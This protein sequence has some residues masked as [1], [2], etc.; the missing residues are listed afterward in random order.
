MTLRAIQRR[1]HFRR[2]HQNI[3]NMIEKA[4]TLKEAKNG[5]SFVSQIE[6]NIYI[7]KVLHRESSTI[8]HKRRK[9]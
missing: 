2:V 8:K 6:R 5:S 7:E 4:N 1:A 3:Q 9:N